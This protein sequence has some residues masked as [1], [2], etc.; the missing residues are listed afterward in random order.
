MVP[1]AGY[2]MPVQYAGVR[3]EHD[4]VRRAVGV[5]D[6]S[7]MGEVRFR[8]PR[9]EDALMWLLTNAVR[10]IRVGTAQYNVMCNEQGGTVD[11]VFVY[12]LADDD[13]LVVVNAA[14]REKD[15]AWMMA[16]NPHGADIVDESD[17]WSLLAIQG[18]RAVDVVDALTNGQAGALPRRG[19]Y[20]GSFA[21]LDAIVARTGYTGEDGFEVF[22]AADEQTARTAWD[23]IMEAGAPHGIQ[24]IGLGARDTLRLEVGNMLYGHELSEELSPLQA[25]I[26]WAVKLR[27]PGGFIGAEALRDRVE[28]HL[29]AAIVLEGKRIA[30]EGMPVVHEEEEVGWVTSGTRSPSLEQSICLAYVRPDLAAP[31][32]SLTIQIRK[33]QAT[34]TVVKGRF[35]TSPEETA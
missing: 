4:Q 3:S 9:A 27:K 2:E 23:A 11:D 5:F 12:R 19:L 25:G 6:V 29:L 15:V 28:S 34:G 14:N 22:L 31:G 30:R 20:Q 21:G 33:N 13:F 24:P 8:G 10:R 7:H 16:N 1:F 32:T 26:G 17:Q 35:Y 18:P